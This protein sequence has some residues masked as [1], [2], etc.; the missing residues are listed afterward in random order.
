MM[1]ISIHEA[2]ASLDAVTVKKNTRQKISIH[3]ALASL[4]SKHYQFQNL[5]TLI[6]YEKSPKFNFKYAFQGIINLTSP[7]KSGANLPRNPCSLEVRTITSF[8][9]LAIPL[10][11]PFLQNQRFIHLQT[12]MH[13]KMFNLMIIMITQRI[14]SQTVFLFIYLFQQKVF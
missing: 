3:E 12:T 11:L 6:F 1:L 7:P 4:D 5:N 13:T 2:L 9:Y 10:L 14:K 8:P